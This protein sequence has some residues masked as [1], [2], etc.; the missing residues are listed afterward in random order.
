MKVVAAAMGLTVHDDICED[1][2]VAT[3]AYIGHAVH[4]LMI[5]LTYYIQSIVHTVLVSC[6]VVLYKQ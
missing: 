3:L 5:T 2:F 4:V 1:D 6:L